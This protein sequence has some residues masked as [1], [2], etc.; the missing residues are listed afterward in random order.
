MKKY[1]KNL[2]PFRELL[3]SRKA[4]FDEVLKQ[5]STTLGENYKRGRLWIED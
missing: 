3:V 5:M 2:L 1:T 4:T